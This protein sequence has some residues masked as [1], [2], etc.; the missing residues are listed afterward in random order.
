MTSVTENSR[1]Y[2]GMAC[3]EPA[4]VDERGVL[5]YGEF[6]R[7]SNALANTPL[8]QG[9]TPGSVIAILARDHRGLVLAISAAGRAGLRLAMM[10]TGFAKPPFAE[11]AAREGV[12]AVLHDE[13]SCDLLD[14]LIA[15]GGTDLP[16]PLAQPGGF[17]IL[18]S[19]TAGLPKGSPRC[20]AWMMPPSSAARTMISANGCDAV[21]HR[22]SLRRRPRCRNRLGVRPVESGPRHGAP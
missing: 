14:A 16:N 10:N 12:R 2:L 8:A 21:I 1:N 15:S 7:R 20:P 11:V 3:A 9:I 4:L 5:T 18:T 22:G 6:D 13:E 19:G 17:I